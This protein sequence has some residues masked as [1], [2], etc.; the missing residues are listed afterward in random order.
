MFR[1]VFLTFHGER[2]QAAT[3]PA[4]PEEQEPTAHGAHGAHA[5]H[6]AHTGHGHTH[7]HDAPVA[8]A[9][10][11][12]ILAVGSVLAG[13]VGVPAALGG[14]NRIEHFLAPSF[15]AHGAA[16]DHGAAQA[17]AAARAEGLPADVHTVP[18]AE[19]HA[20]APAEHGGGEHDV[21]LERTLMLVSSAIA[22]LGIGLAYFFYIRRP[23]LPA[24]GAARAAPAHRILMNKYYVDEIYDAVVVQPIRR[25]SD[26]VLWR[27]VD[28]GVI[29]GAVNATGSVVSGGSSVLRRL[30]TGSVRAYAASVILGIVV[31]VAYYVWRFLQLTVPR[32]I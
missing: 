8:M 2:R 16:E 17:A 12:V 1:L 29:D 26:R 21:A 22:L 14:S 30:Q 20:A 4:H 18:V 6:A 28:A 3:A 11:L 9:L 13:F 23:D 27:Q 24:A 31:I 19:A 15:S 25:L 10:A 32:G 5:V 7:L